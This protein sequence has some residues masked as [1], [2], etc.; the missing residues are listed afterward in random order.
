[1]GSTLIALAATG[2]TVYGVIQDMA[3]GQVWNGTAMEAYN[4]A[5]WANY[6]VAMPEQTGSGRYILTMPGGL[7]N[8]NYWVTPYLETNPPTPTLGGD[9]GLDIMRSGWQ[10]GNVV[11]LNSPLNVGA[12]NG[13]ALAAANLAVSA[14]QFVVGAAAAGTLSQ[15][16][17]TTNLGAT[18]ANLYAGRVIYFTSGVN[19]GLAA[20]ITAYAVTGGKLTFIAFNNQPAP[21][22]P[23]AADTFIII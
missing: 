23:S 8:G 20:F 16:Q 3:S 13:V 10:N 1:M 22:A 19:Q 5:H 2:Q 17:M 15:T 7:P 21:A 11:D 4:Q 9:N 14:A 12:I 18:V 6:A